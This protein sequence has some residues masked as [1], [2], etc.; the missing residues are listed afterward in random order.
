[1]LILRVSYPIT[2]LGNLKPPKQCNETRLKVK[3][4]YRNIAE[5]TIL[6][7]CAPKETVFVP[8]IPLIPNDLLFEFKR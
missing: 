7:G 1:M 3:V 6:T 5:A 4:L 8:R 2:L